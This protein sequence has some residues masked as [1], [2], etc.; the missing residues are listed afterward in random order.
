[1]LQALAEQPV[2]FDQEGM[3]YSGFSSKAVVIERL[4]DPG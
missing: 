3:G 1:V 4:R 2:R